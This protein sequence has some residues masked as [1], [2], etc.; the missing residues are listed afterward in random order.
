[1]KTQAIRPLKE[2]AVPRGECKA[3]LSCLAVVDNH[4]E[5]Y[6]NEYYEGFVSLWGT[7]SVHIHGGSNITQYVVAEFEDGSR[8]WWG[9]S[10]KYL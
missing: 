4:T 3:C 9:S 7:G 2:G 8:V 5:M 10:T 1:M 6:I